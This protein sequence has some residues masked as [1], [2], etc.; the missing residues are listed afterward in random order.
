MVASVADLYDLDWEKVEQLER[1]GA[2]SATNLRASIDASRRRP[3]PRLLVG[4]NIRH[5]GPAGAEA[6]A[7][8]FGDLDTIMS[9]SVEALAAADGVG[10]RDRRVGAHVGVRPG[11]PRA[12]RA[13]AGRG[14]ELRGAAGRQPAQGAGR[15]DGGRHR[16]ARGL[17]PRGGRGGHQGRAAASPRAACRRRRPRSSSA[18]AQGRRR[19]P[20]PRSWA[21]RCSTRTGSATSSTRAISRPDPSR[22]GFQR[23]LAAGDCLALQGSECWRGARGA[24]A[25]P[26]PPDVG[27]SGLPVDPLSD[28][29]AA[30]RHR[31]LRAEAEPRRGPTPR[32]STTGWCGRRRPGRRTRAR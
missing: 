32:R 17:H 12:H 25:P 23:S 4:L 20:R 11:Q 26:E 24:E 30:G 21:S 1:M 6:L 16:H 22:R 8:A 18:R 3:L 15:A 28:E 31:Q 13:A 5:L 14:A 27:R 29:S 7:A 9:S 19:S 10:H 2:T